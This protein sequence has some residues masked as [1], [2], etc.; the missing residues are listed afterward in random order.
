[1]AESVR[2]VLFKPVSAQKIRWIYDGLAIRCPSSEERE[3]IQQQIPVGLLGMD[4]RVFAL[5]TAD[6]P[7][8]GVAMAAESRWCSGRWMEPTASSVTASPPWGR[9]SPMEVDM[10]STTCS[11]A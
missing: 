5:E 7:D 11:A 1:M 4:D 8:W 9:S 2:D 3:H 10:R 6:S